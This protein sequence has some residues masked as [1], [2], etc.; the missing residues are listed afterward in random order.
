[1]KK[2][3]YL[4]YGSNLNIGQMQQRCPDA[5][6]IGR[7][8][9]KGYKLLFKGSRTGSY[10]TIEPERNSIVP[11][12]VWEVTENDERRL[13]QYEGYPVFYYKKVKTITYT[14]ISTGHTQK[15]NAFVYIMDENRP[16]GLPSDLYLKICR[17]GYHDFG[18]E[19]KFL[20]NAVIETVAAME[21]KSVD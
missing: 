5:K 4:A 18:I 21:S 7:A 11:V 13:D 12:I 19:Q 9:L 2:K 15:C 16:Y 10:L 20:N 17:E 1:M 8:L 3:Y 6:P 14:D